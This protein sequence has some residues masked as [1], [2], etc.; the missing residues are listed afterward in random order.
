[1]SLNCIISHV[2]ELYNKSY[3]ISHV[4]IHVTLYNNDV[5]VVPLPRRQSNFWYLCVFIVV[6]NEHELVTE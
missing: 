2:I 1:M 5:Y 3:I 6:D 4:V